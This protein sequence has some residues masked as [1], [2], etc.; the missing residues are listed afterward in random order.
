M[1]CIQRG[2]RIEVLAAKESL[3]DAVRK[4]SDREFLFS[5]TSRKGCIQLILQPSIEFALDG[6]F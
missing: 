5:L 1:L 3:W 4:F 6:S 2:R